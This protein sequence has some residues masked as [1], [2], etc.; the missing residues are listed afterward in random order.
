MCLYAFL[1]RYV[2]YVL[3]LGNNALNTFD[4]LEHSGKI[5]R[6][7]YFTPVAPDYCITDVSYAQHNERGVPTKVKR[8]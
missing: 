3:V 6:K 4:A 7:V 2:I 1:N 5:H 8:V